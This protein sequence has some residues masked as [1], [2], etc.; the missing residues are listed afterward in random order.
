VEPER[1]DDRDLDVSWFSGTG[2]GGQHRNKSQ[3]SCRL[4]HI[5]TG[6]VVTSQTRS[7]D[8]SYNSAL[9]NLEKKLNELKG[10]Q[11]RGM[12]ATMKK[13]QV[14]SGMRSD[15]VR[16]YRFRDDA[17]KDHRTGKDATC[18][19]VMSGRFDKLW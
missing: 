9:S 19:A 2:P 13:E 7:R 14:G 11:T 12:M 17:V 15:K 8:N 1:I 6:I 5:P 10:R 4:K 18:T 16:T 3:N